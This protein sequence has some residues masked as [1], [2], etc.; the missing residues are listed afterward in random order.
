MNKR[1]RVVCLA[2][3]MPTGPPLHPY[4]ILLNIS[5]TVW[6]LWPAQDF[7]FRGDNYI[8]KTV[9]VVFLARDA[10]TKYYQNIY[11]GI[12]IMEHTRM[13]LRTEGQTQCR[14]LYPPNLSV[15]DKNQKMMMMN[16]G[17]MTQQPIRVI[18]V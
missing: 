1:V 18:C 16:S 2:S 5:Q 3:D 4:Q 13:R 12:E 14:S 10:P 17:L 8:T 15:G 7:G 9:R 6:E 11:K